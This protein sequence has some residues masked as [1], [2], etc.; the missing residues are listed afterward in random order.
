MSKSSSSSTSSFDSDEEVDLRDLKPI[1]GYLSN[2]RELARQ[3]FKSVKS[4]KIRMMLPQILKNANLSDLEE[5][6]AGELCG[7]SEAR[8]LC[9]LKGQTMLNSSET[10]ETDDSGPSLEIIS[11]TEEWLTDTEVTI[12]KEPSSSNVIKSKKSKPT[13]SKSKIHGQKKNEPEKTKG[14]VKPKGNMVTPVDL[15]V[16]VKKEKEKE[17]RTGANKEGESL[18][19]LL[20]LEMRARAIRALIRKE[21]D[22]IPSDGT[23]KRM[24]MATTALR[25]TVNSAVSAS[26]T[27]DKNLNDKFNLEEKMDDN[28]NKKPV[29]EGLGKDAETAEDEDVVFV[30]VK[31]T[32]TIELLSSEGEDDKTEKSEEK[33]NEKPE[34]SEEKKKEDKKKDENCQEATKINR[35]PAKNETISEIVHENSTNER[36]VTIDKSTDGSNSLKIV[37]TKRLSESSNSPTLGKSRGK[38]ICIEKSEKSNTK[39]SETEKDKK[40]ENSLE[41]VESQPVGKTIFKKIRRKQNLRTKH[42]TVEDSSTEKHSK[43]ESSGNP[44]VVG[45]EVVPDEKNKKKDEK[46]MEISIET[47][48]KKE[49]PENEATEKPRDKRG[50]KR[51]RHVS[52]DDRLDDFEEIIDLDD[53]PDDME[54]MENNE[55]VA[56]MTNENSEKI[57]PPGRKTARIVEDTIISTNEKNSESAETWASRYYQTDDVQNVIKESKIQSEIRKRLRERQRLSKVNISPKLISPSDVGSLGTEKSEEKIESKPTGSV[58]EYLALKNSV[59]GINSEEVETNDLEESEKRRSEKISNLKINGTDSTT[60]D[61][62][63]NNITDDKVHE[64]SILPN[65]ATTV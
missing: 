45:S 44:P 16:K 46:L 17:N 65:S 33:K 37:V 30:V 61:M 63:E 36:I 1:K 3:L 18:L 41:S 50:E 12:K 29:E 59:S 48:I 5:W 35:R 15:D 21:E 23:E 47:R 10:S 7:M 57:S 6:C 9:I 53:Y 20:E 34:K 13:K 42:K 40:A 32:P 14:K 58:Q 54:E 24:E 62:T 60:K 49:L 39:T 43:E 55:D 27:N 38:K 52:V 51:L 4:D 2:R 64:P 22:I 56:N 31:P 11:D 25:N 26:L 28:K 19:D 8:I